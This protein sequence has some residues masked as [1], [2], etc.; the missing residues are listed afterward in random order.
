MA[1]HINQIII[2]HYA[3]SVEYAISMFEMILEK[4]NPHRIPLERISS[5]KARLEAII[6]G[7]EAAKA[8]LRDIEYA[9]MED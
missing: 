6:K 5:F 8:E 7:T 1:D 4:D 9:Q 2:D 3:D